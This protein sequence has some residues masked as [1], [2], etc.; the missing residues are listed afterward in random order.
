MAKGPDTIAY[1]FAITNNKPRNL[2]PRVFTIRGKITG[3]ENNHAI[4]RYNFETILPSKKIRQ[5]F[6]TI[7]DT[8]S[9]ARLA[10]NKQGVPR[11][12]SL[13]IDGETFKYRRA[14]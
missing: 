12:V 5:R 7:A 8:K 2:E 6:K 1:P 4:I 14:E 10:V 13:G 11:L 9:E 3:V